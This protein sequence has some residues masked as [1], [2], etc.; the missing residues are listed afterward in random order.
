MFLHVW[1]KSVNYCHIENWMSIKS[2]IYL[3]TTRGDSGGSGWRKEAVK[4]GGR[5]HD[6][7]AKR[8]ERP[9]RAVN[10]SRFAWNNTD[11]YGI[12]QVRSWVIWIARFWTAS[13]LS[14]C[15]IAV[16][17]RYAEILNNTILVLVSTDLSKIIAVF[18][19]SFRPAQIFSNANP[20]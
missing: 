19:I 18:L 17:S 5:I 20:S 8:R 4:T 9:S 12:P 13:R 16:C 2:I 3:T 6:I 7:T 14:D 11:E 1:L 15:A 10:E